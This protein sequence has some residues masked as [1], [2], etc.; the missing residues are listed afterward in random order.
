[1]PVNEFFLSEPKIYVYIPVVWLTLPQ[2]VTTQRFACRGAQA[3]Q[4][5]QQAATCWSEAFRPPV[6]LREMPFLR[7]F[8]PG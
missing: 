5:Q 8:L 4:Q 3:V 2:P 1:M 7:S 6:L